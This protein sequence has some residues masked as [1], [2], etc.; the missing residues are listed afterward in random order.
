M[1]VVKNKRKGTEKDVG[2]GALTVMGGKLEQ[3]LWSSAWRLFKSLQIEPP[4][5]PAQPLPA[6]YPTDWKSTHHRDT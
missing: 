2:K 1:A 4:C 3:P 5:D 6:V